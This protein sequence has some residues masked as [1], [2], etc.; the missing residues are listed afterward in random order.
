MTNSLQV[1]IK[2]ETK[3]AE[4]AARFRMAIL[5]L[6]TEPQNKCQYMQYTLMFFKNKI[7]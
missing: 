2:T 1:T 4:T 5:A 7:L 6:E 3:M